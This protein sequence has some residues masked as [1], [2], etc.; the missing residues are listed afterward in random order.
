MT[1]VL[2]TAGICHANLADS[3]DGVGVNV[4]RFRY[5]TQCLHHGTHLA[6]HHSFYF[7]HCGASVNDVFQAQGMLQFEAVV[8]IVQLALSLAYVSEENACI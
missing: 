1:P 3:S 7:F 2:V 5:T 6:S 4:V 8:R